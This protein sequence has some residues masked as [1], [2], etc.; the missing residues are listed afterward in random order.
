MLTAKRAR[1]EGFSKAL[2]ENPAEVAHIYQIG[3]QSSVEDPTLGQVIRPIWIKISGPLDTV[4]VGVPLS[5]D[6]AGRGRRG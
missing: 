1:A 5:P 6:R 3:G 2:A 4:K